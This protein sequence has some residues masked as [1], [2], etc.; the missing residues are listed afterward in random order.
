LVKVGIT[1]RVDYIDV[2]RA[3]KDFF[4]SDHVWVQDPLERLDLPNELL[5][6]SLLSFPDFDSLQG[7]KL[8]SSLIYS[9]EDI[10]VGAGANFEKNPVLIF[11]AFHC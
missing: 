6:H 9:L 8:A 7:H 5:G 11:L 3:Y 2:G 1:E 10:A 4:D